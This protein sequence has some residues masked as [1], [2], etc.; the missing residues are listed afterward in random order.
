MGGGN[1]KGGR[2]GRKARQ[3]DGMQGRAGSETWREWE[4]LSILQAVCWG[5]HD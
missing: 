2:Q 3:Q 5:L 4:G 1:L